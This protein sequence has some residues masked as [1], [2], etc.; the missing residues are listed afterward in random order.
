QQ[1]MA[2]HLG[3]QVTLGAV[4]EFGRATLRRVH[5][6]PLL[7]GLEPEEAVWMNHGDRVDALPAGFRIL[8]STEDCP[9]AA[10]EDAER[11]LYGILFHPEVVH[12]VHGET[13]L[14]NFVRRVCGARADWTPDALV[15][16]HV[17]RIRARVGPAR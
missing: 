5:D 1:L 4:R 3:G 16:E 10:I 8:A 14:A 17:E 12:T 9:H 11:H 13:L 2:R 7:S 6:S 15:A